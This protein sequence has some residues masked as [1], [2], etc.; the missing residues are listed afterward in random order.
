MVGLLP[1]RSLLQAKITT[2]ERLSSGQ[3]PENRREEESNLPTPLLWQGIYIYTYIW[4][5][6]NISLT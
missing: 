6:Y 5:N 4:V 2:L 1:M 3:D